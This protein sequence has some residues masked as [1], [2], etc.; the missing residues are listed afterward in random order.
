MPGSRLVVVSQGRHSAPA[1]TPA[2]FN[3]AM[4]DFLKDN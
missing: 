4:V 1:L 3:D 2:A